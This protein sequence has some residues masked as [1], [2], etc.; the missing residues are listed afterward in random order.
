MTV[1]ENPR[2]HFDQL[3]STNAEALRQA[4]QG[5]RGP[6]WI[7]ADLQD[8]GRGRNGR[9]WDS[10][11]GNLMTSLLFTSDAHVAA[12][13]QISLVTGVAVIDAIQAL[14][15]SNFESTRLHLKWPN[16][17][18]LDGGKAG[19]VLV[20]SSTCGGQTSVVIGIGLNT[21]AAPKLEAVHTA[22]LS[23][24]LPDDV[25]LAAVRCA[26]DKSM[27]HWLSAWADGSGFATVRD[28]WMVHGPKFGDSLQVRQGET[29]KCGRYAG[30]DASG[31]L[32]LETE[33]GASELIFAGDVFS[34]SS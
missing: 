32:C 21:H 20:E 5:V 23:G 19:G 14:A 30:L 17:I 25:D 7:D 29:L 11:N 31:A 26:L 22:D 33:N 4:M 12:I 27:A 13:A 9:H 1:P 15:H 18:L 2:L 3:D 8:S 24:V 34:G 10:L 6:L 28:R 16:D